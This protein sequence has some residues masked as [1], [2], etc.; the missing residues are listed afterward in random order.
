MTTVHHPTLPAVSDYP[1][2]SSHANELDE[3]R[4][5]FLD[6]LAIPEADWEEQGEREGVQLWSKADPNDPYAVPTVKGVTTVE[7][8]SAAAF[9]GG[10]IQLPGMRKLW[11]ARFQDGHMLARYDR[12][13]F[14]FYTVM[15]GMSWIVYPRSI[16]GAQMNVEPEDGDPQGVR[17]VIQTSVDEPEWAPEQK[18]Q[19]RATLTLS[20]WQLKPEGDNLKITYIVKIALNGSMPMPMVTM[21]ATETPLCTGR[22]RDV[23]REYGHA[24]YVRIPQGAAEPAIT[25]QT[26]SFSDPPALPSLNTHPREYRC[27][28]TTTDKAGESFEIVYDRRRM[29]ADGVR[30]EVEGEEGAEIKDDDKGVLTVKTKASGVDVT[31][32]VRPRPQ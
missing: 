13:T 25:F 17:M 4:R 3:A 27:I 23:F 12:T 10:V 26:E 7:G 16:C 28:F 29:Y 20:G 18:G 15:K 8:V 11:D 31:V 24:P 9:L 14:A 2:K 19:T 21:V 6:E 1:T 22:A 32:I 30:V 5:L